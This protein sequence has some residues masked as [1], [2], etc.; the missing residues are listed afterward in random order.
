MTEKSS[1]PLRVVFCWSDISGYMAACWRALSERDDISAKILAYG[2]SNATNFSRETMDG[3]DW[4]PLDEKGRQDADRIAEV[5]ASHKPDV[6]VV[7]GWLNPAYTALAARSEFANV[8]FVMTMDTPWQGNLRQ[9]LAP[10]LLRRHVSRMDAV[11]VTGERAY[12]YA[13]RLRVPEPKIFHGLYGVDHA[14]FGAVAKAR[15][16]GA[17]PRRFLFAGRYAEEKALDVLV[18]A[19]R[20]YRERATDPFDLVTCGQGQLG[21]LLKDVPGIGDHGFRQPSEMLDELAAA[22]CFVIASRFDPWPLALVEACSAGLPVVA[23]SACGSAVENLRDHVNGF[24]VATGDAEA[25]AQGLLAIDAAYDRLPTFGAA[26]REFAA[27]YSADVWV[28]RWLDILRN[29]LA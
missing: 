16:S 2:S 24:V 1:P 14:K 19:Y 18:D 27:A 3:I 8:R 25:L 7:A 9:Q 13:L 15:S 22:G 4:H 28:R 12:Q 5:V 26:S 23:S 20:R 17:W 6:I 29:A 21:E 11:V 10:L